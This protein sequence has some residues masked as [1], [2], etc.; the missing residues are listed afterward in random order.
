MS[1]RCYPAVTRARRPSNP[2]EGAC[3]PEV[4]LYQTCLFCAKPLDTNDQLEWLPVGRRIAFDSARG[5]LWIVCRRCVKWNLVPFDQRL[6]AIDDCERLFRRTHTRFST[7]NIGLAMV[8]GGLELIRIGPA[9]RPEFA[10]WR[11]GNDLLRRKAPV[12]R[13]YPDPRPTVIDPWTRQLTEV[14]PESARRAA[15]T[16]SDAGQWR[17][18]IPYRHENEPRRIAELFAQPPSIRDTPWLGLFAGETLFPTLGRILPSL[19]P[20][21]ASAVDV[22]TAVQLVDRTDGP[23]DLLPYVVG[24]PLKFATS[25]EYPVAEIAREIRLALEIAA[26]EETERRALEGELRLLERQWREADAVAAFAD[27]L[28]MGEE[29]A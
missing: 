9:L 29:P 19:E 16:I 18:E 24:R 4:L 8:D 22:Q 1:S 13:A 5:R 10:A 6:E 3:V 26:H 11:Y 12:W 17:L 15:L 23:T 7:D 14:R 20:R 27:R 2:P 28:A 25:R 21:R